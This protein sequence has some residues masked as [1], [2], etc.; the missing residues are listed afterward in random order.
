M[1]LELTADSKQSRAARRTSLAPFLAYVA[2]FHLVWIA[3]PYVVYPRLTAAFG[4]KTLAYALLQL[5]IRI[6][7][8]VVPVW[9]YLR[10]VD[11][12]EPLGYLKLKDHI[13]R[14]LVVA[15][16]LTAVNLVGMLARFGLPHPTMERVTWNSMLGTSFLIGFIEEIPYRGFMLQKFA[17]RFNFLLANLMTSLLF[18]AIH[19][20]GWIALHTL[21]ADAAAAILVFGIVM[22]TVFKYSDSL[23]API[24]TH[25]ANDFLSFVVFRL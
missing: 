15:I 24:V 12:V 13:G 1:R 20:P 5:S 9:F 11:R 18:L 17:E 8:W 6:L 10:Y 21:R 23:W 25:S 7:V 3:W 16:V 19:L 4:D 22:A 14:G 2:A